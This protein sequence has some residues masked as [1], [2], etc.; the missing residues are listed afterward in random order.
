VDKLIA[1]RL[2][3]MLIVMA[4][5]VHAQDAL[6]ILLQLQEP[7]LDIVKATI[8]LRALKSY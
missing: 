2:L 3:R 1:T 7:V 5:V 6:E 8:G 4:R